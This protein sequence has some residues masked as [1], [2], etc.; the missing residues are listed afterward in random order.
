MALIAITISP[1]SKNGFSPVRIVF[2]RVNI[3]KIWNLTVTTN[4]TTKFIRCASQTLAPY[5]QTRKAS[6]YVA[7][8]LELL[9][10]HGKYR[11]KSAAIYGRRLC[12]AFTQGAGMRAVV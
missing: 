1:E 8:D 2:Q 5:R 12:L 3:P 4:E 6:H 11:T 9:H 10:E 7:H